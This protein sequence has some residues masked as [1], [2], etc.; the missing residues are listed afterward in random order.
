MRYGRNRP[1]A[2]EISGGWLATKDDLGRSNHLYVR[3]R[4]IPEMKNA[5]GR[6]IPYTPAFSNISLER[7]TCSGIATG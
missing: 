2:P 5:Y 7:F 3:R 4:T 6:S 1:N